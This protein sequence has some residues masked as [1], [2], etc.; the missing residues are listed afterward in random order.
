M[1]EIKLGDIAKDTITGFTGVVVAITKWLHGCEQIAL[2]PQE[3]NKDGRPFD[4]QSF[5][6]PQIKLVKSSVHPST[7]RTG[8]PRS[9][10]D[11]GR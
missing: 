5:D 2:Q 9:E 11:R 6:L 1:V 10:P 3:L 8:G 4:H 7:A